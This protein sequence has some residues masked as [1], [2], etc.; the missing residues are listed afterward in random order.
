MGPGSGRPFGRQF[1]RLDQRCRRRTII[2]S[3]AK[4][5]VTKRRG[6]DL[7]G[8]RARTHS[9]N[10]P[11]LVVADDRRDVLARHREEVFSTSPFLWH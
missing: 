6:I 4:R 7:E 10:G 5:W 1:Q 8:L 2:S 3:R 9:G 11:Y